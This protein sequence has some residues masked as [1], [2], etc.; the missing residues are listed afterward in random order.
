MAAIN[1]NCFNIVAQL[2]IK[3]YF[4]DSYTIVNQH[5]ECKF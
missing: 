2:S 5:I 1:G 4:F 3:F